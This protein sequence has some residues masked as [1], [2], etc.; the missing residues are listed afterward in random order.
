MTW[1]ASI[2]VAILTGV[3]TM[4][5][6]GVLA[7]LA[8]DWYR[9]S[10]MEGASGYF[11]AGLAIVGLVGGFLIGLIASRIV[12]AGADPGFVRALLVSLSVSL[13]LTGAIGGVARLLADVPPRIDGEMLVV[14]IEVRYPASRKTS[15]AGDT[16]AGKLTL[17]S[18][19]AFSHTVRIS[20]NGPYWKEDARESDGHWIVPG[21]VTLFT[22]RG[23]RMLEVNPDDATHFGFLVPIA[24]RPGNATLDW[25]EWMPRARPGSPPLPDQMSIRFRIRRQSDVIRTEKAG[26]FEVGTMPGYYYDTQADGKFVIAS[27]GSFAIGWNGTPVPVVD[28]ARLGGVA[29]TGHGLVVLAQPADSESS[30]FYLTATAT[31]PRSDSLG[32]CGTYTIEAVALTNDTTRFK[33]GRRQ[34]R[35]PGRIDRLTFAES[36]PFLLGKTLLD[37]Q[38]GRAHV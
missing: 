3:A 38:I 21:A 6:A 7:S 35:I 27:N 30:C 2:G 8:V 24:R 10:G 14:A 23:K 28:G 22:E 15:P 32:S 4:L 16:A 25:S 17:H 12:A 18:I 36:G 20:E 9:V 37:T 19:P 33:A 29:A 5:L 1:L 31:G 11:V 13:G 26:G 34:D